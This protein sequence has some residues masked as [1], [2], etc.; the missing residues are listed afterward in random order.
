MC[1]QKGRDEDDCDDGDVSATASIIVAINGICLYLPTILTTGPYGAIA[2][3][4]GR[5]VVMLSAMVGIIILAAGYLFVVLVRTKYYYVI[6]AAANFIC[7]MSGGYSSFIMSIF[8]YTADTTTHDPAMRKHSYPVTEA[9]IFIPKLICPVLTGIWVTYY[10]FTFP[11]LCG[12]IL[13]TCGAIWI[14]FMPESL[15]LDSPCRAIPLSLNPLSTVSN[16]VFLFRQQP[17]QGRS[18]IPFLSVSFSIAFAVIVGFSNVMILYAKHTYHWGPDLVGY[19]D[20]LDGGISAFSM[21]CVP[22]LVRN[23]LGKEYHLLGW[24]GAGYVFR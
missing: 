15:P 24:I 1:Y 18:P 12:I 6:I 23:L 14:L 7:G 4:Y 8:S 22:A 17:E 11:L 5:K 16:M 13:A 9:C 3:R 20:G 21:L 10:G 2:N 19:Y